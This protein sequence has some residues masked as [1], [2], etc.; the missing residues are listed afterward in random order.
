MNNYRTIFMNLMKAGLSR[1]NAWIFVGK[2]PT[3]RVRLGA[4]SLCN[5]EV[6]KKLFDNSLKLL[7]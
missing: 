5:L 1:L 3:V 4:G 2:V 6:Y 7:S